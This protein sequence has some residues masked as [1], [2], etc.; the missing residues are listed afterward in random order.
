MADDDDEE[1]AGYG[2]ADAKASLGIDQASFADRLL[3]NPDIPRGEVD[4]RRD[5]DAS[6]SL[7][8]KAGDKAVDALKWSYDK[9]QSAK[10]ILGLRGNKAEAAKAKKD[11][12]DLMKSFQ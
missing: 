11:V 10:E 7:F 4:D 12:E 6:Q 1:A 8:D 3:S 2:F 5:D 9:L